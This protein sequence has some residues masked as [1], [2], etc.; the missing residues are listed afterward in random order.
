MC[1][2]DRGNADIKDFPGNYTQY[3]DWKD[4]QDQLEKEAEAA[5][6]ARQNS[7]PEDVYKRQERGNNSYNIELINIAQNGSLGDIEIRQA[8]SVK[9][10]NYRFE[11]RCTETCLLYTSGIHKSIIHLSCG[12]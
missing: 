5:L 3:R 6:Q 12:C 9:S 11:I 1:I 10:H 2:R 7:A 8:V 4:V